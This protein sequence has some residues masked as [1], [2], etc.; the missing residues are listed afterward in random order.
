M[1]S[2][3]KVRSS[4]KDIIKVAENVSESENET[5]EIKNIIKVSDENENDENDEIK[6]IIK[7]IKKKILETKKDILNDKEGEILNIKNKD[8]KILSSKIDEK[9]KELDLLTFELKKDCN[10]KIKEI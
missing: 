2:K 6:D 5:D 3:K 7:D 9:K 8:Y 10:I 4:K 1:S